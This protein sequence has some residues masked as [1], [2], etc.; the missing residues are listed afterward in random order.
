MYRSSRW[1]DVSVGLIC[2]VVMQPGLAHKLNYSLTELA[3]KVDDRV[4][5]VSHSLHLDDAVELLARLGSRDGR[6]DAEVQARILY[7][8]DQRFKLHS[9]SGT[10]ALHP[11]GAQYDGDYLWIYQEARLPKLPEQLA[12]ESRILLDYVEQQTNQINLVTG[13]LVQ[14]MTLDR[15]RPVGVFDWLVGAAGSGKSKNSG[16]GRWRSRIE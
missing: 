5:H 13:D 1:I 9:E 10:V 15:Q 3:W 12:V 6:L 7:Y 4:L 16:G 2:L 14:S 11:I 8:V